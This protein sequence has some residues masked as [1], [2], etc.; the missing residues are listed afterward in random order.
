MDLKFT[1]SAAIDA[2][3]DQYCAAHPLETLLVAS[4]QLAKELAIK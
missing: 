3:L 1:D 2:W 4:R